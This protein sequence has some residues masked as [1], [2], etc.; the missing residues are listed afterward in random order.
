MTHTF[1]PGDRAEWNP[2]GDVWKPGTVVQ[3]DTQRVAAAD[4]EWVDRPALRSV[5]IALD[6]NDQTLRVSPRNLRRLGSAVAP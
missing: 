1:R 3:G 6:E 4:A 2:T 5:V